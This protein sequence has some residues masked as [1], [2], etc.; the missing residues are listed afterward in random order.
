MTE[1]PNAFDS[2]ERLKELEA[3]F[4]KRLEQARADLAFAIAKDPSLTAEDLWWLYWSELIVPVDMIAERLG[5]ATFEVYQQLQPGPAYECPKCG[6]TCYPSS[7]SSIKANSGKRPGGTWLCAGCEAGQADLRAQQE[8]RWEQQE[9]HERWLATMP[10]AEY[11]R[12]PEWQ[13]RRRAALSRAYHRCQVCNAG[14]E[15]HV[16]HRTYERRGHE[17]NADLI[18]LCAE[19]HRRHHGIAAPEEP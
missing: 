8:Q 18:V 19:C 11:L 16:H 2:L 5:V 7:R 4:A 9:R 10:Y 15:L 1:D 17:W 6:G 3:V 13:Q 12:T 14:A